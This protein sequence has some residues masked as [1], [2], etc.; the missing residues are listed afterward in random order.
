M[1]LS[2]LVLLAALTAPATAQYNVC[3]SSLLGAGCGPTLDVT[4]A[5]VGT[6]G[7]QAITISGAGLNP[8]GITVMVWGVTNLGGFPLPLGGCPAYT[9]FLWGHNINPDAGGFYSW[10]RSWPNSVQGFYNIQLGT[11]YVDANN[12]FAIE[13]SEARVA[14]CTQ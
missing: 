3:S 9:E 12:N 1:K 11:L 2:S 6:A 8:A 7:N 13:T 4:F 5:P 10:S 14:V